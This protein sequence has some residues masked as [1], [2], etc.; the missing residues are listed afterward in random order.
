MT[1]IM[2]QISLPN[3]MIHA[4]QKTCVFISKG[5]IGISPHTIQK[6]FNKLWI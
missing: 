3:H 2:I 6:K 4:A 5:F 1:K